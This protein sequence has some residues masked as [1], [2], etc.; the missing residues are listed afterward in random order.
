[1]RYKDI[2]L[3]AHCRNCKS[4]NLAIGQTYEGVMV[5]CD[6]CAMVVVFLEGAKMFDL[7]AGCECEECK[8]VN[9][10]RR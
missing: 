2:K 8:G 4:G 9:N 3:F 1:M 7:D 5:W 6:R 10:D